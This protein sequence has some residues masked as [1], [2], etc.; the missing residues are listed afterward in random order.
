MSKFIPQKPETI[1]IGYEKQGVIYVKEGLFAKPLMVDSGHEEYE[2]LENI[3]GTET[4]KIFSKMDIEYKFL[5]GL[6]KK[7]IPDYE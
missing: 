4:Q 5:K 1:Y 2:R 7:E 3:L 6:I